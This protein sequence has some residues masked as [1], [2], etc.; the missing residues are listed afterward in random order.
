MSLRTLGASIDTWYSAFSCSEAM[1]KVSTLFK[2]LYD[3]YVFL[4]LQS[5][6]IAGRDRPQ[7]RGTRVDGYFGWSANTTMAI[8]QTKNG[9]HFGCMT[10]DGD[11][12]PGCR[13]EGQMLVQS[14]ILGWCRLKLPSNDHQIRKL[15]NLGESF[16]S[17]YW[18]RTIQFPVASSTSGNGGCNFPVDFHLSIW[19]YYL[20]CTRSLTAYLP[21]NRLWQPM[22]HDVQIFCC[23]YRCDNSDNQGTLSFS[24]NQRT[25]SFSLS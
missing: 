17:A 13:C 10:L 8:Q 25:L 1:W 9:W 2:D 15:M 12:N 6:Q 18:T 4:P 19:L 16:R 3:V 5:I 20:D 24:G 14:A 22:S 11:S 21:C 23:I 7:S